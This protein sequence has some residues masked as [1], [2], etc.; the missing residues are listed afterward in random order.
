MTAHLAAA[1]RWQGVGPH[2]ECPVGDPL[3]GRLQETPGL[4]IL[5]VYATYAM[6][7]DGV[8]LP[9]RAPGGPA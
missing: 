2:A 7:G 5:I 3:T 8:W 4:G 1:P 6:P 9:G